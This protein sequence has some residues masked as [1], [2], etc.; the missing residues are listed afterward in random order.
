MFVTDINGNP[1]STVDMDTLLAFLETYRPQNWLVNIVAPSYTTIYVSVLV[2]ALPSADPSA[3]ATSVQAALMTWL[4]PQSWGNTQQTENVGAG[5]WLNSGDGFSTVRYKEAIAVA[6]VSGVAYV[7]TLTLGTSPSP[8][9]TA[10]ITMAGPA[11]LA[12]STSSTILVTV[13]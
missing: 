4:N 11:P 8:G 1:L 9:G 10:D 5:A 3:L 2:K 13:E 12:E 6:T 7:D